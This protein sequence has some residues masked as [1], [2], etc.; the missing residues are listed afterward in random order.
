[1]TKEGDAGSSIQAAVVRRK[2]RVMPVVA[3]PEC[4]PY[5][6]CKRELVFQP[7]RQIGI[8]REMTAEGDKV[9]VS[10]CNDGLRA[11]AVESASGNDRTREVRT[12]VLHRDRRMPFMQ[13]VVTLDAG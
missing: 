4:G 10:G 11:I 1:M 13:R 8:R 3:T 7:V 2:I 12:Q 9:S 5:A 6:R